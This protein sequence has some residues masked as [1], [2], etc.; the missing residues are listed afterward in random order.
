MKTTRFKIGLFLILLFYSLLYIATSKDYP[1]EGVCKKM[2]DVSTSLRNNRL[3]VL[4][5][6]QCR[7]SML[8]VMVR[9]SI[10]QNWD[11]LADTA[12]IFLRSQSLINYR[13]VVVN[14]RQDT[15]AKKICP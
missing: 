13:T 5:A 7:D 3:Y 12:C 10:P 11:A 4:G 6:Y 1:C 14:Q 15:L 2:S 8:C 9:D